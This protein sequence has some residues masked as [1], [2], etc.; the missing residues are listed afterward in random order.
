[1]SDLKHK[2][3]HLVQN[4]L[5]KIEVALKENLNPHIDIVSKIASHILFSGGK[6]LRPL[7]MVLSS[8]ICDYDSNDYHTL[9]VIFEYLHAATLL[10]D[11]L[12][13]EASL[14]RGQPVANLIWDNPTAVLAG[15][16]LLAR[17]LS[18]A[19]QTNRPDVIKTVAQITEYM[20]Q[21]EIYQLMR[22]GSLDLDEEEYMEIIKC[23]TAVLFQ[24]ACRVGALIADTSYK[25]EEELSK[26]GFNLGIAF[27]MADD[28]LDYTLN[29]TTLGKEVGADLKEGKLTLPVIYSLKAA[30]ARD[31]SQMQQIITNK[32]FS[33]KDFKLLIHMI[34]KHGGQKYTQDQAAIY[35]RNAKEALK[36]FKDSKTKQALLMLADYA[37]VR[38]A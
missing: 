16:F 1:M 34:H 17:S 5:D 28:L 35:V 4:D 7:L 23:K 24:G 2:I 13:D 11:D 32:A 30:G 27:Q 37:L 12:V 9:S 33:L 25:K 15:D 6:R 38:K 14:R 36:I 22:R 19:A 3:L 20:S 31:R 26:Y 18:I 29:T 21:G 8:R 10:H